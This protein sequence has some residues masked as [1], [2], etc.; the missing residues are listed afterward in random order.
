MPLAER[1]DEGGPKPRRGNFVALSEG[2]RRR[3]LGRL[4]P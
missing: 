4:S 2:N 1:G 3:G